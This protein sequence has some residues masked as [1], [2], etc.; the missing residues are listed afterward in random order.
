G[1]ADGRAAHGERRGRRI[2][3]AGRSGLA[4]SGFM[5]ARISSSSL[6]GAVTRAISVWR[7]LVLL[8]L[9]IIVV[10]LLKP[11]T[12]LTY[13]N[14]RSIL[15]SKSVQALVAVSVFIPMTANQFDL[16][17]GFNIGISQVLAIGLQ[18]QGLPWWVA[19]IAV[20]LMGAFVGL[21]NGLLVTRIKIDSF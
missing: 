7:L 6:G 19:V 10:S 17:A 12:F 3:R 20:V 21:L 18:A 13:F 2:R 15:S 8:G 4:R 16:S 5:S 9:L 11:G 1:R 14:G